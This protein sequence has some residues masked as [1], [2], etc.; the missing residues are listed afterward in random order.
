M[1]PETLIIAMGAHIG[2]VV[3]LYLILTVVRAPVAWGIGH[4]PDGSDPWADIEPRVSAN[5]RNQFEWPMLFYVA[6]LLLLMENGPIDPVQTWLAWLFVAGR[7]VHSGVQILTTNIRL[8]GIVFTINFVAVL[9]M[10]GQIVL[11]TLGKLGM[12]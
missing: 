12:S 8:R 11:V 7:V 3:I 10:W 9:G 1:P 2:W 6:C 4:R 5:L